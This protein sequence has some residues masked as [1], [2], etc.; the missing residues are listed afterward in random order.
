[1]VIKDNLVEAGELSNTKKEEDFVSIKFRI[2][3]ICPTFCISLHI[4][5]TAMFNVSDCV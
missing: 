2:Q 5:P 4:L 3:I 1:M